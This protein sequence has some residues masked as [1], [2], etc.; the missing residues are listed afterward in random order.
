MIEPGRQLDD[1]RV[2]PALHIL[3]D[4]AHGILNVGG[5]IAP[6]LNKNLELL[7]RNPDPR[8]EGIVSRKQS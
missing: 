2:A 4:G 7:A 5:L 1:S 8:N 6:G 3:D